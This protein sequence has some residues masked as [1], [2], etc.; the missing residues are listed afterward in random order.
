MFIVKL[1]LHLTHLIA[2]DCRRICAFDLM[3]NAN[4]LHIELAHISCLFF[5]SFSEKQFAHYFLSFP[6]NLCTY[7]ICSVLALVFANLPRVREQLKSICINQLHILCVCFV[8]RF[9]CITIM[10]ISVHR[11][12]AASPETV[13]F[14]VL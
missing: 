14:N 8:R 1:L 11:V 9:R 12:M 3:L 7:I 13:H 4:A 6:I 10:S 5:H 2:I